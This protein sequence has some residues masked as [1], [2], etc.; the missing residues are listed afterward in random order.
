VTNALL[1]IIIPTHNSEK[2][3]L[4]CVDSLVNQS[5]PREKFEIIVVD[6]G[7]TDKTLEIVKNKVDDIIT[8]KPCF[9]GKARNIGV[10]KSKA[11]LV[12]FIDSD[13]MAKEGWIKTILDELKNES[14]ITGPVGNGHSESL[15][16]WAEWFIEFGG[17]DEYKKRSTVRL[18]PGC[19]G[20][21]RKKD[22]L[23]AG[24]FSE[25]ES[26]EDVLLGEHLKKIGIDIYFVP[27]MKILHLCRTELE[28]V[29]ANM[30]KL[31]KFFVMTRMANPS[32]AFSSLA[33][34]R[35]KVPVIFIG[36][37]ALISK[38]A[39][40][41]KKSGKLLL[42][43]PYVVS[44]ISSFCSGIWNELGEKSKKISYKE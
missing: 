25:S 35:N 13:C 38:Y 37:L 5:Y 22:F 20:A 15:V 12:A 30:K 7:S 18:F 39:F 27:E 1:S 32:I 21:C 6:D 24:G 42:A 29:K 44:G 41:A 34:G 23:N 31:G 3:I 11:D 43:F 2:T 19:N 16:A 14:V 4:K 8:T 33:T 9:Q 26:N 40:Q 10:K 17:Y 36:K 28:R